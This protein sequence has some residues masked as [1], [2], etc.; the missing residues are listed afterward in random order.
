[1][2][3][4]S[5][6]Y[7]G[8]NRAHSPMLKGWWKLN[9]L[10]TGVDGS[11][12]LPD[13]SGNNRWLAAVSTLSAGFSDVSG[14]GNFNGSTDRFILRNGANPL[15]LQVANFVNSV[16]PSFILSARLNKAS[17]PGTHVIMGNIGRLND[18]DGTRSGVVL[19]I[20]NT[21]AFQLHWAPNGVGTDRFETASTLLTVDTDH[22][23]VIGFDPV[24]SRIYSYLNG[25][26]SKTKTSL[27]GYTDPLVI[28]GV[29]EPMFAISGRGAGVGSGLF[30]GQLWDCQFYQTRKT[31]HTEAEFLALVEA[32]AALPEYT[33]LPK[34][35]WF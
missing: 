29:G 20:S 35:D 3:S 17:F 31:T 28:S 11:Q 21:G 14:R 26:W 12:I 15:E 6:K 2:T 24:N 25:A 34:E 33:A 1:M 19:Q 5:G 10:T 4:V 23:I 7:S 32:V 30:A 8:T 13:S 9:D 16:S 22:H 27:T 18:A